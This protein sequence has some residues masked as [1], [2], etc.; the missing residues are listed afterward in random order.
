MGNA[1]ADVVIGVAVVIK[2]GGREVV[3]NLREEVLETCWGQRVC[4]GSSI[5]RA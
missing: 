4:G 5:F 1:V 2:F 3:E